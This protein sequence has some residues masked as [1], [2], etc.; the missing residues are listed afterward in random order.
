MDMLNGLS[1]VG[2]Y[3]GTLSNTH[4]K[5]DQYPAELNDRF[6]STTRND[7]LYEF[8]NQAITCNR[9]RSWVAATGGQ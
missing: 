8:I 9:F 1:C 6:F 7:L 2:C 4:A 5:V 3:A